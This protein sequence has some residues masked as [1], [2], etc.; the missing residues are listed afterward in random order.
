MMSESK[1]N[2]LKEWYISN[3]NLF[4]NKLNGNSESPFHTIRKSAISAFADLGFPTTK[5]E[6]WR[7]TNIAPI[8]KH[9]FKIAKADDAVDR[10]TVKRF[11]FSHLDQNILVFVNGHYSERLSVLTSLPNDVVIS[12]LNKAFTENRALLESHLGKYAEFSKE[13]FTALNTAFAEDGA[14]IRVPD[15]VTVPQPLHI[16][17][18]NS[19]ADEHIASPRNLILMGKGSQLKLIESYH[20]ISNSSYFTNMVTE[21]Y[22]AENANLEYVKYQDQGKTA[23]HVSNTNICQQRDSVFSQVTLDL[24]G[25]FVRNNTNVLLNDINCE[26]HLLGFFLGKENQLIDNHTFIDH[27]KPHCFSNE[28]YKGILDDK[29]TGVFN[30]KILVRPDAQ[31]TNAL[32]SNKTLLLTN[33]AAIHAK[34]QLEIFADDVKCTHGAT[35][36]Q[37][38]DEALFYLRARGIGEEVAGAMLRH[39]FIS[40]VLSHIDIPELRQILDDRIIEHFKNIA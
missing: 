38:D 15:N 7:H 26:T 8:L 13:T 19:S 22:V 25:S 36:G 2:D 24:G 32:Q 21:V 10:D 20:G 39:A 37:L 11:T 31:K 34:P 14:V 23:F 35:I 1:H 9:K 17:Y 27:A 40:D 33:D 16:I 12:S 29:S 5:N 4:E 3:F 30:G 28:L 18:V 6:E